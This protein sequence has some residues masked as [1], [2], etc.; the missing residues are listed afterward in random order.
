MDI[1]QIVHVVMLGAA[2]SLVLMHNHL[3]LLEEVENHMGCGRGRRR[4]WVR[5][6]NRARDPSWV[7]V[8]TLSCPLQ[9]PLVF[10]AYN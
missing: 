6:V 9:Y 2:G 10:L 4:L 3:Q 8:T 7:H 5:P 1:D